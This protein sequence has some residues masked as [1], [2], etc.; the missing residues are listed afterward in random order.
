MRAIL[1]VSD[2]TGLE[3]FATELAK[4]GWEVFS[5]GGTKK[6]LSAAGVPVHSISDITGFPEILDGR[7]KTLHPMVHGGILARRDKEDHMAQL[8][9][10]GITPIDMVVVNLYPFVQTVSKG[11]VTL[12]TALENIDI[13]GPAMIRASAKNFPGVIIVT[14]PGDYAMII[15]KLK[16]PGLTLDDRKRLAQKAFQHTAMYDT[17]ISQYLWQGNEGFPEN[18]TIALKKRYGLRYGENPHQPAAFYA[19]QRVG[20]SQN[21][22]ITWAEQLWGKELSFN[23]ILDADAAWSTATDFSDPTVAIIKHTNPC[24]LA[25][26]EDLSEAYKKAFEGDPVSAYGGIV[27]VNRTLTAAMAEAMRG[28]FY[29]ISIAPD[30]EEAALDILK[31]RKDLRILKA[32]LPAPETQP[33]LDYRRVKGGLLVQQADIMPDSALSLKTVTKRAPTEAEIADMLFAFRAVK[34][35]KSNAIALVKDRM[36]LGMGAGQ[37]N[38]VTSV[39]IAVKRAGEKS[40]GSVLASDAMFPF[41]D[42]VLQAAA[43]GVVAIIQ[44]GGSIRDDASIQAADENNIAMVFTGIRHFLH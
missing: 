36:L 1:S 25:S 20:A 22:G 4:L 21:S 29:E 42:S 23:N 8:A 28:T 13:G 16:G 32:K 43:A 40:K 34:H 9:Q 41:N 35:I 10:S 30:Y 5:T 3:S 18:M 17:A 24:G 44:P 11:D 19:E 26:G 14:D 6:S 33:P 38:R 37:P 2:K 31:K 39:D 15:D 12:E 27:A 7:V